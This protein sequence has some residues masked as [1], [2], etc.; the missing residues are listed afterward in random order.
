[1]ERYFLKILVIISCNSMTAVCS[2]CTSIVI[3]VS[4]WIVPPALFFCPPFFLSSCPPVLLSSNPHVLLSPCL[5]P[6][7]FLSSCPPVLLSSCPPVLLSFFPPVLT[8]GRDGRDNSLAGSYSYCCTCAT[9]CCCSFTT[10]IFC[11]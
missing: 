4:R 1:M 5:F 10:N 6:H 3:Q 9:P 7:F 2:A 11:C 8:G